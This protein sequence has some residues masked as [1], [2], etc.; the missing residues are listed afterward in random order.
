MA[1]GSGC[2]RG[3]G[4]R[5]ASK[6]TR[7]EEGSSDTDSDYNASSYE[8][9]EETAV[10]TD[11]G[12]V[13]TLTG[14]TGCPDTRRST[15]GF[16]IFLGLNLISWMPRKQRVVARSSTRLN[17]VHVEIDF[18]FVHEKVAHGDLQV[19][20]IPTVDQPADLLTKGL[21]K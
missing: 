14:Q 6:R 16:C 11:K 8:E 3:R 7:T 21:S 10:H 12:K 17:I 15:S 1:T 9:E 20:H 4:R 19:K 5:G 18:H 2:G 13:K